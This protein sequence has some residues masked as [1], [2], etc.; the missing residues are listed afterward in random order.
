MVIQPLI[1]ANGQKNTSAP[2]TAKGTIAPLIPTTTPVLQRQTQAI[3][4]FPPLP[5]LQSSQNGV[6]KFI[7]GAKSVAQ[8]FLKIP[9]LTQQPYQP[10]ARTVVTPQ[11][12]QN[13]PVQAP[14]ADTLAPKDQATSA[15]LTQKA[16]EEKK[17]IQ[18]KID[19]TFAPVGKVI[20][21]VAA[22][23]DK[24]IQAAQTKLQE[25]RTQDLNNG[26]NISQNKIDN[27]LVAT[28][29]FI[30]TS[31]VFRSELSPY[32]GI[33]KGVAGTFLGSSQQ[34]H[35]AL[36]TR[37]P[38]KVTAAGKTIETVG[39][40]AGTLA[41][42]YAG[43]ELLK[44][45]GLGKATLPTLF[46]VIGQTSSPLGT[47]WKQR[48]ARMPVDVVTG[49]IMSALPASAPSFTKRGTAEAVVSGGVGA[50]S[51]F[52][53][54]LSQGM[55]K[56]DAAKSAAQAFVVTALLHT[57]FT[58]RNPEVRQKSFELFPDEAR[59]QAETTN[60]KGTQL[61]N[62][63]KSFADQAEAQ[64]KTVVVEQVNVKDSPVVKA[65][66][67]IFDRQEGGVVV[68]GDQTYA[69]TPEKNTVKLSLSDSTVVRGETSGNTDLVNVN[70]PKENV[71]SNVNSITPTENSNVKGQS[72]ET[73]VPDS[74]TSAK[75]PSLGVA[76]RNEPSGSTMSTVQSLPEKSTD[77][78][79]SSNRMSF[80]KDFSTS[81]PSSSDYKKYYSTMQA[82][83]PEFKSTLQSMVGPDGQG[84][85]Y[86]LK[87]QDSLSSK[88]VRK[89]Q[90]GVRTLGSMNDTLAGMVLSKNIDQAV[91]LAESKGMKITTDY[92]ES[93]TFLGYKGVHGD[94]QLS[95]GAIAEVQFN[96]PQVA[97]AKEYAHE[98]YDK[99]RKYIENNGESTF[100]EV[101]AKMPEELRTG[102][103]SD[104]KLSND[105]YSG[106]VE[107]PQKYIDKVNKKLAVA[108][109]PVSTDKT[110][111][112]E[113]Q[114]YSNGATPSTKDIPHVDGMS[115]FQE[116]LQSQLLD[117]NGEKYNWNS[118]D[119]S[120]DKVTLTKDAEKAVKLLES[121]PEKAMKIAKGFV[122]PT[123]SDP[124]LFDIQ[125]AVSLKAFDEGNSALGT[126]IVNRT[127][128][129]ATRYGQNIASLR[130]NFNDNSP[131]NF[132]RQAID[133][134]M[135][136]L[137][138]RLVS[139]VKVSKG[140]K[141]SNKTKVIQELDKGVKKAQ[142]EVKKLKT[143][144]QIDSIK[145][146][147]DIIDS[148]KCT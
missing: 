40:L 67:K 27:A 103:I 51:Q 19:Q 39:E 140:E 106:K 108:N 136:A 89:N 113:K 18:N 138:S 69:Q 71:K 143:K 90:T 105:I 148:L 77:Q 49:Y 26:V 12:F 102:F 75:L 133:K 146:A 13:Q 74:K 4:P 145:M 33:E 61:E 62:A 124:L 104:V 46:T 142:E 64:G 125:N 31:P 110:Q 93:P 114:G 147:Q 126:E 97:A 43:G 78:T 95:N 14:I 94:L 24:A 7:S 117:T 76:A 56:E 28:Q 47:T 57:A 50:V 83:E 116:R 100:N 29:K 86:R 107:T 53:T 118:V 132:L 9:Q 6:Q 38:Q 23:P 112:P 45:G 79:L 92:R 15:K 111:A 36:Y 141:V 81:A 123:A 17:K 137:G 68:L 99:Y 135:E 35:D 66:K 52:I 84:Y 32:S 44:A 129:T 58:A 5:P 37:L 55:S 72:L 1:S 59:A 63:L 128:L 96:T 42:F 80:L 139:D 131:G 88:L 85:F 70:Q 101:F 65:V 10:P 121:D 130:G 30:E 91:K 21:A 82:V 2:T 48:I 127:S 60:I 115:R 3:A 87:N 144:R 134:K 109:A 22:L 120:Y 34:V 8:D 16:I 54:S 122:E 41:S 73:T 11:M 25:K 98:I 20:D 119:G